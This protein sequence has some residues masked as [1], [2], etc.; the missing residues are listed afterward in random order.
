MCLKKINYIF[1]IRQNLSQ[2]D[3]V[4]KKEVQNDI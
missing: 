2:K 4:E 3:N 1:G